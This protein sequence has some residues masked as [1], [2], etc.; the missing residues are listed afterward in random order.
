[1]SLPVHS[2]IVALTAFGIS[3]LLEQNFPADLC[4]NILRLFPLSV[5]VEIK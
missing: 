3:E 4:S 2:P 1:M 5:T